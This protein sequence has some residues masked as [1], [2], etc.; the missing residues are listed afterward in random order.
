MYNYF[1]F[2]K[3]GE[4]YLI[5]NDAGYYSFLSKEELGMLLFDSDNINELKKDELIRKGFLVSKNKELFINDNYHFVRGYKEYL[6]YHTSLHIFV[7]TT[8]CNQRCIYCQASAKS[9]DKSSNMSIDTARKAV[10]IAISSGGEYL[11]FEFQGGEPLLNF[12]TIKFIVEYA[13]SIKGDKVIE[14]NIVSNLMLLDKEMLDFFSKYNFNISTS[15]DGDETLHNKNRPAIV[16]N[17]YL[18]MKKSVDKI[19]KRGLSVS[20]IQTTTCYSIFNPKEIVNAYLKLGFYDIF[21]RPLTKL[22]FAKSRWKDIGYSADEFVSFYEEALNYIVELNENG[23]KM[24]EGHAVILLRK[25]LERRPINY[26]ELRSPCGAGIGQL[27]Y[28]YDGGIYTCDEGRM[29]AEM[30]DKS[31]YI[32]NVDSLNFADIVKS[33]VCKAVCSA[34]CLET[35]PY[36]SDCVYQPYC[37]ICPIL[38]YS[39]TGSLFSQMP[40]DFKCKVYMGILDILFGLIKDDDKLKI[41]EEWI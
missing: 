5:T 23:V 33:P 30:G 37:G 36:C 1:N 13:E 24:R 17:S 16:G 39:E 28:Y 12:D 21:L 31:F 41:L 9:A 38:S 40:A 20:A 19:R 15:I 25:I 4:D 29:L 8:Q 35:I 32:G 3:H 2:K 6:F 11:T 34:S 10:N 14:Y 27:A 18:S 22:G 7:V 26:M